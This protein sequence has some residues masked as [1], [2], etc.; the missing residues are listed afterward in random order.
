MAHKWVK[1]TLAWLNWVKQIHIEIQ[2]E[3]LLAQTCVWR[4]MKDNW[5][6]CL[7][8]FC[9]TESDSLCME[10]YMELYMESGIDI[11]ETWPDQIP[12]L[13]WTKLTEKK[14]HFGQTGRELKW[15]CRKHSDEN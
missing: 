14:S 13:N 5:E 15:N 4:T 1:R 10:L 12:R 8:P 11:S 2:E 9:L 7:G 6:R 3:F